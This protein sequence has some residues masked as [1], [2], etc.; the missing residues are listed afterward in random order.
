MKSKMILSLAG[1]VAS[2]SLMASA[3]PASAGVV[4]VDYSFIDFGSFFFDYTGSEITT[5]TTVDFLPSNLT[6][7]CGG[8]G[9]GLVTFT[10]GSVSDEVTLSNGANYFFSP[11]AFT[12]TNAQFAEA[13]SADTTGQFSTLILSA[14]PEP[15]IWALMIAGV[16]M[17]G[18][19][20]RFG[21]RRKTIAAVA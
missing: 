5:T 13:G 1:A 12:T 18:G 2:A 16:A 3:A 14:A 9:C 8:A 21:G 15:S 19:A 11:T 4:A 6:D 10:P 17:V 7:A 20:L